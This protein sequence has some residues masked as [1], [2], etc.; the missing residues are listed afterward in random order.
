MTVDK[1]MELKY[2][3]RLEL[4]VGVEEDLNRIG[5]RFQ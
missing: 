2:F 3:P 1:N 4:K 5:R